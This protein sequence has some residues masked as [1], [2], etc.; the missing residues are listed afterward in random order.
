MKTTPR[1]S[2]PIALALSSAAL[3]GPRV[4]EFGDYTIATDTLDAG[5]SRA[6]HTGAGYMNDG[7]LGGIAGISSVASPAETLKAGY[8]GQLYDVTG[9]SII[10]GGAVVNESS[11]LQLAGALA[12]DDASLIVVP[13]TDI[14]WSVQSGPL[15]SI[16]A[17]GL[18]AGGIV[19]QDSAAIARGEVA[20]D[21]A[22][23]GLTVI[24]T[25][26]D[27]FGSYAGDGLGDDWQVQYFGIDDPDAA[28]GID[29]DGDGQDNEFE[30][31]AGLIPTDPLS[32]FLFR[33]EPVPGEAGKMNLVFSPV[34]AGRTYDVERSDSLAPTGWGALTGSTQSDEGNVRTI[35]DHAGTEPR[36]FYRVE[37]ENP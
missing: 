15:D 21:T 9:F 20:G 22:I 29:A 16:D 23:F 5:G 1:I 33:I 28:P 19:Y 35:T 37:I 36:K 31:T 10:A 6:A 14:T 3:A 34:V 2:F 11:T 27:N 17:N 12:L 13:A 18:A 25:I 4:S 8:I 7:S 26:P 32:R 30:F 24:D